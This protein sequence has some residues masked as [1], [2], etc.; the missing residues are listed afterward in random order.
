MF[1]NTILIRFEAHCNYI[2]PC[3]IPLVHDC[4]ASHVTIILACESV[5]SVSFCVCVYT[6]VWEYVYVYLIYVQ[7]CATLGLLL[8]FQEHIWVIN[9]LYSHCRLQEGSSCCVYHILRSTMRLVTHL[10]DHL[11]IN[12][13][14]KFTSLCTSH[15]QYHVTTEAY[16]Y[17]LV[18]LYYFARSSMICSI[19]LD[20]ICVFEKMHRFLQ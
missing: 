5:L 19:Q 2:H 1:L 13:E 7:S 4:D 12:Q 8:T 10:D 3:N 16:L 11:Q 18:I 6:C 9:S 15:S 17:Y 20:K 14:A